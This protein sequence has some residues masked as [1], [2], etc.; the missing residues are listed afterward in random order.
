MNGAKSETDHKA[1]ILDV[2]RARVKAAIESNEELRWDSFLSRVDGY[3]NVTTGRTYKGFV[4]S[5]F[6]AFTSLECGGDPRFLTFHQMKEFSD[7][8]GWVKTGIK[9]TP[10]FTPLLKQAASENDKGEEERKSVLVGFRSAYVCNVRQTNLL[11]IG[12]VPAAWQEKNADAKPADGLLDF[13]ARLPFQQETT[14]GAPFYSPARDMVGIPP[15]DSFH[16]SYA[17][18]EGVCHELIHWTGA[19]G[20]LARNLVTWENKESYSREELVACLGSALLLAHL[21][22]KAE[23]CQVNNAAAYLKGWLKPLSDNVELLLDAAAEA[24]RAVA[25]L[26]SL[27]TGEERASA[28]VAA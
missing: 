19:K 20:R 13:L 12:L 25:Y 11:E 21:D 9:M 28:P 18:A 8:K 24:S 10:I 23:D 16:N 17:H 14:N 27:V 5:M 1:K 4:N 2:L 3:I 7:G 26:V 22:V 15:F 6:L